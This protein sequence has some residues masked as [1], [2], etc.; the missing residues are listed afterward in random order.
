MNETN[1][2]SSAVS[3]VALVA[4]VLLVII[5]VIWF[6]NTRPAAPAQGEQ[7]GTNIDVTLPSGSDIGDG[8]DA[9]GSPSSGQ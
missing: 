5:G 7:P 9:G 3:A 2:S 8:N 4:I 6:M 1:N